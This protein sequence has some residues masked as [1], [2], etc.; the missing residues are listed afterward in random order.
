MIG[1]CLVECDSSA[2]YSFNL[3]KFI[4]G[5]NQWSL[6]TNSSYYF[7]SG[8]SNSGFSILKDL[9]SDNLSQT[10]WKAELVINSVSKTNTNQS[11][12]GKAS[13]QILVNFSP[14]PGVCEVFPREGNTTTLF[15]IFCDNWTDTN[16]II[17]KYVFYGIIF[18]KI[19][20]K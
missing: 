8:Q 2:K 6:F 16:G 5:T 20:I 1:S 14:L 3:Y 12:Q 4:S 10:I 11:F 17:T 9:F 19:I 13:M 18:Y 15:N 7:T